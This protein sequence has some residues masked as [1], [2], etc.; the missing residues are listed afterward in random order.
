MCRKNYVK[1]RL[2]I[3]V[4]RRCVH[5][6]SYLQ[7]ACEFT[8][9]HSSTAVD[10]APTYRNV[11]YLC[12]NIVGNQIQSD[13][14]KN[15]KMRAWSALRDNAMHND[16]FHSAVLWR[17]WSRTFGSA[18]THPVIISGAGPTGLILGLELARYGKSYT[19]MS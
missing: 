13:S 9:N 16:A 4:H 19:L 12:H 2:K 14:R 7:I 5:T 15:T 8:V 3:T 10:C 18:A 11:F 17:R 1:T 6:R